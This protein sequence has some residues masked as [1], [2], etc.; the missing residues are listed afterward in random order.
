MVSTLSHLFNEFLWQ[1]AHRQPFRVR[2][3]GPLGHF[4]PE[5]CSLVNAFA[6]VASGVANGVTWPAALVGPTSRYR[7][8]QEGRGTWRFLQAGDGRTRQGALAAHALQSHTHYEHIRSVASLV[9]S[10]TRNSTSGQF[11]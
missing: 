11:H 3:E 8:K 4:R 2:N 5:V 7:V 9:P 10:K 1:W 6:L